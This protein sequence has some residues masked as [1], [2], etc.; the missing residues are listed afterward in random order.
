M[1]KILSTAFAFLAVL[2]GSQVASAQ[3]SFGA[4]PAARVFFEGGNNPAPIYGVQ[5]NFEDCNRVSDYFG[6]SAGLDFGTY[7]KKDFFGKEGLSEMYLD[8]PIRVKLYFPVSDD[9][10]LFVFGGPVPSVCIGSHVVAESAKENRFAEGSDYTRFDVLAGGGIGVELAERFR[11][12][13]GY[14]HGLLDRSKSD[15]QLKTAAAKF[16]VSYL[17]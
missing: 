5:L 17:F 1:K 7:R 9:F 3:I 10:Q 16:T 8:M 2:L 6:Y 15:V 13:L 4:G 11:L 12:A 14:D